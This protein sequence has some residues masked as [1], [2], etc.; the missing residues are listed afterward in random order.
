VRRDV[1]TPLSNRPSVP[2]PQMLGPM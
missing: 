2:E 1:L